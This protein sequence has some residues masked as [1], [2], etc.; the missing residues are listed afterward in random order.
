M[1]NERVL[2]EKQKI[3]EELTGKLRYQAGVLVNYSGITVNEDTELRVRMRAANVDYSVVKN[4]L[5]RFAINKVGF[6]VLDE[7]LNGPTSL[8]VSND[9]PIAPARIVKEYADKLND[10]FEIK[11]GFLDGKV[12]NVSEVNA[13]ASI[14]PLPI[15]RAQLLGTMLAPIAS[16]AVVLKAIAEKHGAADA[17]KE[18]ATE[19]V[20][21]AVTEEA[22]EAVVET[23]TEV[24]AEV[25]AEVAAE[26]VETPVAT[27]VPVVEAVVEA[28]VEETGVPAVT[29][30]PAATEEK[31]KAATKKQTAKKE[32][33]NANVEATDSNIDP[34]A[35]GDEAAAEATGD[36]GQKPPVKKPAVK[37][38][39]PKKEAPADEPNPAE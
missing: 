37:K 16:L 15:L 25:A 12:L 2:V 21:E 11:G 28:V 33:V 3:V 36:A 26:T 9:D 32:T 23:V 22:A 4:T 27:E 19:A 35:T 20:A 24:T 17:P 8:A 13:L 5:M 29:E 7:L 1:P 14:P 18:P 38:A 6:E 10:Y 31:P 39:A 34:E 30:E